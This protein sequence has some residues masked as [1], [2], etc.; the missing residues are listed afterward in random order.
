MMKS[1]KKHVL[2]AQDEIHQRYL[3][4]KWMHREIQRFTTMAD[5]MGETVERILA[6]LEESNRKS[7]VFWAEFKKDF[8]EVKLDERAYHNV[9]CSSASRCEHQVEMIEAKPA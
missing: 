7:A 9:V 4:L 5:E 6:T 2:A 3:I 8:P 1:H